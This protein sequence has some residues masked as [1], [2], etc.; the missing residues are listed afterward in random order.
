MCVQLHWF[1]FLTCHLHVNL[2]FFINTPNLCNINAEHY[3]C[4][5]ENTHICLILKI[6]KFFYTGIPQSKN[7]REICDYLKSY[8]IDI[9]LTKSFLWPIYY[10]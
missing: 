10:D 4:G 5:F 6:F 3:K 1:V 8:F 7:F 9:A 2:S